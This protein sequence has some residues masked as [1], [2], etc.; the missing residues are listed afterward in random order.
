MATPPA[1]ALALRKDHDSVENEKDFAK[2]KDDFAEEP[3]TDSVAKV[4]DENDPFAKL[5]SSGVASLADREI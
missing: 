1:S 3:N 2:L 4:E 5:K